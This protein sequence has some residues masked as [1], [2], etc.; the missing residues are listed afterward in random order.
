MDEKKIRQAVRMILEA[1]GENPDRKGLKDT[2]SR[3]AR[4][5]KELFAG[6]AAHPEKILG[7]I[8]REDYN[9][10]VLV[11]SIPLFSLCEHHLL[12]F[13]GHANIAYLPDGK[14]VV[15]ISKLA[16][17]VEAFARRAQV[18]ERLTNQIADTVMETLRPQGVMVV[19]NAEH[20]CMIMR[21]VTKPGSKVVTSAMRGIFLRDIRT[22]T[23]AL[24]L[25]LSADLS[26][27][28]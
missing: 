19:I 9:E 14:R 2:P 5:Y 4:M 18:Q 7:R 27:R 11:K 25:M 15:G 16:R 26:D 3:V 10:L 12:P 13:F 8:F 6:M 17:L 23:E 24:D 21:G 28:K 1:V 20:M 22:R